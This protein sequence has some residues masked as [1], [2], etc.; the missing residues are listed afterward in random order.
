MSGTRLPQELRD[1][2]ATFERDITANFYA[3]TMAT[4]DDIILTRGAAKGLGIY[5]DLARDGH[6]G[7]VLRKRRNAVV[8]R[9]YQV[10]PGGEAPADVLAAELVKAALKRIRFD[11]ACRGLL[12][13]VLTGISVAE[14]MWEAAEIE[15][16]G[17]RRTWIVPADIR[18]RN[19]RRFAFDRDGKLR[20]LTRENRTQGI[21]VPDRKFIQVRYWAEENEDAYGRGLGYDLFWPVFFKRNGVAL[22]NALI[23]KHGQPFVYAEYPQGTSDGDVDRLVTMIQGIARGAGVAVPSG[24]LIKMLE[25]SKTGTADMHKELVQAMNAEISKIVLGETLTTEM[26]QNGARAA[27]ETHN[28]VRTELAD[29]D[30]DML[31]EE[32]NESLLRWM[33]ELNL[34][35]AAQPTVWRKA[36]EEPD[37]LA[38]ATLDEKLF[39]VGYEPTEEL[40]LERYGPGYRRI[41]QVQPVTLPPPP[42]FAEGEDPATIPEALAEQ[43][44]RR[45]AP[46]QAAMLAAIRAE[47]SAAVDFADLETRLLRLSAAMPVGRLV[48]ELTPALIVGHLA[49]RSDAQDEATPAT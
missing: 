6:A 10:E 45:G 36:P 23:E 38:D 12:S 5:Q 35:G 17:T 41:A 22:W 31:S 11:R 24:T 13:A 40:V 4:R 33:V 37:L 7:A 44:A 19:P 27:S 1:E 39:K 28:D 16:D 34:P 3:F 29:A 25:V 32:L 26:G 43:L 18:V 46:A 14:I 9:E 8:A 30:A 49:G 15:V 47:V 42:A 2:V 21:P 48:D 20:L